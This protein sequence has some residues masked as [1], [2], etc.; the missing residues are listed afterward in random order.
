VL[1]GGADGAPRIWDAASGLPVGPP[2]RHQDK[3]EAVAFSADSQTILTGSWDKTVRIW[4]VPQPA[5]GDAER[6]RIWIEVVS[7]LELD[8]DGAINNLDAATIEE[9]QRR[10]QELGGPPK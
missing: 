2:L 9:R 1:T 5:Q 6:L 8:A 4:T 10:L 3:V 7:G